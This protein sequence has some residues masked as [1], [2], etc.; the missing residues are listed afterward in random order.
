VRHPRHQENDN[1]PKKAIYCNTSY[2]QRRGKYLDSFQ[3][4]GR[5][6]PQKK[7]GELGLFFQIIT[8][9]EKE[10]SVDSLIQGEEERKRAI[11]FDNGE[12]KGEKKETSAGYLETI[13]KKGLAD[14]GSNASRNKVGAFQFKVGTI[15]LVLAKRTCVSRI[16]SKAR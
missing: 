13:G 10:K 3:R 7:E 11:P 14:F 8:K 4:R 15:S 5:N 2:L 1:R 16:T 6:D 9:R 12:R